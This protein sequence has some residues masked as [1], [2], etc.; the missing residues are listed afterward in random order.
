MCLYIYIYMYTY[1]RYITARLYSLT[2][3]PA[4]GCLQ[5]GSFLYHMSKLHAPFLSELFKVDWCQTDEWNTQVI[6]EVLVREIDND[7]V[8]SSLTICIEQLIVLLS[9][10]KTS[11]NSRDFLNFILA[12]ENAVVQNLGC[13]SFHSA[14]G[15]T[16]PYFIDSLVDQRDTEGLDQ[17]SLDVVKFCA[18]YDTLLS[19]IPSYNNSIVTHSYSENPANQLI[20]VSHLLES[21]AVKR[22]ISQYMEQEETHIEKVDLREFLAK[23]VGINT[24]IYTYIYILYVYI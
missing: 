20:S 3:I 11:N 8:I 22:S 2:P 23:S 19:V 10:H 12:L 18:A 16:L 6:T 17:L 1:I 21:E 7:E 14:T 5:K 24:H 4:F 13:L 9:F 15:K